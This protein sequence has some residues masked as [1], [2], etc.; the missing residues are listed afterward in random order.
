MV[1]DMGSGPAQTQAGYAHAQIRKAIINGEFTS[2]DRL[3]Q[4]ELAK[5]LNISVTPVREALSRLK[6]EGL[7]ESVPH[8]GTT[9]AKLNIEQAEEIYA[10]RKLLEPI[11]IRRNIDSIPDE[12]LARAARLINKMKATDD[13]LK[14]TAINEDFHR[15]TMGYDNSW[16]SRVVQQLAGIASP[17][18]IFL[19]PP[20]PGTDRGVPPCPRGNSQRRG[21]S[22]CRT[23]P[24]TRGRTP[25]IHPCHSPQTR[26][27]GVVSRRTRRG[28]CELSF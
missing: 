6:E 20:V 14:F 26:R 17:L 18:R 7:I 19:S 25:R 13:L 9:V 8:R 24:R 1:A 27:S 10:M 15:I 4:A 11:L 3:L 5:Q 16:T 28:G 22:G 23:L 21:R 12:D 2:G